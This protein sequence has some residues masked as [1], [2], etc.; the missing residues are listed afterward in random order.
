[1]IQYPYRR[2]GAGKRFKTPTHAFLTNEGP[3]RHGTLYW[4]GLRFTQ[5]CRRL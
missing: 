3:S 4:I 5:R 2:E 1:M